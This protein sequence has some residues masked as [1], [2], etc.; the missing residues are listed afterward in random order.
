MT[1][2]V[3]NLHSLSRATGIACVLILLTI[4]SLCGAQCVWDG[5][6]LNDIPSTPSVKR[7]EQNGFVLTISQRDEHADYSLS[8]KNEIIWTST[9]S[10]NL[11]EAIISKD[12]VIAGIAY[13]Q[14]PREPGPPLYEHE[15]LTEIRLLHIV[16]I[17]RDGRDKLHEKIPRSE[18]AIRAFPVEGQV[19]PAVLTLH[20]DDTTDR[21]IVRMIENQRGYPTSWRIYRI[22]T[23]KLTDSFDEQRL[24]PEIRYFSVELKC[25]KDTPLLAVHWRYSGY[26]P[27]GEA[28]PLDIVT[29]VNDRYRN[30]WKKAFTISSNCISNCDFRDN[31]MLECSAS[32]EV[33][34]MPPGSEKAMIFE[35]QMQKDDSW[36][37]T[38]K[39]VEARYKSDR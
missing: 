9:R 28:P 26:I 1:G 38:E 12:R 37:V 33:R 7:F 31:P 21:Y 15:H 36:I 6:V 30:I 4:P 2:T 13:T 27:N 32:R 22:D 24:R 34:I 23:G 35:V 3:V 19:L 20:F 8:R 39:G 25:I 29:I 17:G 16:I 5:C 14:N 11:N 18:M 10:F